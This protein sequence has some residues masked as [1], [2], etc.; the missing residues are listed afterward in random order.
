MSNLHGASQRMYSIKDIFEVSSYVVVK[1]T[2][3]LARELTNES[4]ALN[5]YPS[6][7]PRKN[8]AI[9]IKF[10]TDTTRGLYLCSE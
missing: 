3:L 10:I 2:T 5:I 4:N 7:S 1:V 9:Q 8:K 6:V